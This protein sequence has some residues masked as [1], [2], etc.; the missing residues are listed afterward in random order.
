MSGGLRSRL[1]ERL[2]AI[3]YR[4]ELP[5][6]VLR[7]LS[8]VYQ[9]ATKSKLDRPKLKPPCPLIVVGNLTVGGSG[10]TPVVAA[11][12]R[13]VQSMDL[14]V[15][16][17]S[18]GYGGAEPAEPLRVDQSTTMQQSGDEARMLVQQTGLP[19]WVCRH[20]AKALEAALGQGAEV[21]ISDDGLQHMQLPRSFEL[22][23]IDQARAFGNG[24]LL[25]AGPLRQPLDRLESVDAKLIKQAVDLAPPENAASF[26]L[27]PVGVRA[28]NASA[29]EL[30]V[31]EVDA[32]A[33]IADPAS[34]FALLEQRDLTLRRHVFGDHQ[35]IDSTWLSR[36]P[37]PVVM[38]AKDAAR[39][40]MP[41][42]RDDLYVLDVEAQLPAEL[43]EQITEHV[44][45]FAHE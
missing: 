42:S 17:I 18:R 38:T 4:D 30:N 44:R 7:L 32:V 24:W 33:G 10:K 8:R 20:R 29:S 3:W 27:E 43:L 41:T 11:L 6:L 19:L 37:G 15:A 21:V 1:A 31:S 22:C 16:I 25:P 23:L 13:H 36:L 12:A 34:F 14:N 28:L 26:R 35:A 9:K 45:K 2:Q 40:Q 39:L 5:P